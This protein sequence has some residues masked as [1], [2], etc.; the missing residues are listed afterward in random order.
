[1]AKAKKGMTREEA[2]QL[3]QDLQT[4]MSKMLKNEAEYFQERGVPPPSNPLNA[5]NAKT[6][7]KKPTPI[8]R[9]FNLRTPSPSRRQSSGA[10]F[11]VFLVVSFATAKVILSAMEYS[12]IATVAQVEAAVMPTRQIVQIPMQAQPQ[13]SKEELELLKSLDSRRAELEDRSRRLDDREQDMSKKD[14]EFAA[15]L[16]ELRELNEK[17]SAERE[18]ND[19]KRSAQLDQLSN[20]YGSMNP[21]EAA[22]LIEQLDITIGISLLERMPEKRIGQILALMTPERALT[23]T[24]MLS[25]KAK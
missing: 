10:A 1:M 4:A 22:H 18:K 25:G 21:E 3:Y 7:A 17:L 2:G 5:L 19:H 20:V 23:I 8:P 15:R 16:T 13:F 12:G 14:K 24:K 6:Q 11:A 9:S